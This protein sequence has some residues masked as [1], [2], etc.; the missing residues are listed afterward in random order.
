MTVPFKQNLPDLAAYQAEFIENGVTLPLP[1][2]PWHPGGLLAALPQPPADRHG[3]PWDVETEPFARSDKDWPLITIVTPSFQQCAYLEET[4]RSVLLQNYPNLEF[5]VV[6]GG[7]TDNSQA[8]INRYRPWLSFARVAHDRGQ[9]HAINLG[10]SLGGGEIYGW[11]NS[12]DFFMPGTLRRIAEE[13]RRGTEF[14][15]GDL[16]SL[17]ENSGR[18]RYEVTSIAHARYVKFAGLVMQ[19]GSFWSAA[20]HKPLWEDQQCALDYELW[21]RLLPGLRLRHL[22]LPLAVAREHSEA[23]TFNPAMKH[24]WDEDAK[25]N[26]LAHPHLYRDGFKSRLLDREF[27]LVKYLWKAWRSWGLAAH[28]EA[29]RR[30]CDWPS[31]SS[32]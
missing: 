26:G 9:S 16:I 24:R 2:I 6:D 3:W 25:R 8:L 14:L 15:Y 7:S 28:I 30:Q 21:I 13:W 32:S 19:A 29:V 27:R 1:T 20:R 12:D 22:R 11:I 31:I 5:V 4:L 18:V 17:D 23:K 10:F